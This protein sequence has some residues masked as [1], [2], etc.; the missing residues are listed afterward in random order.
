MTKRDYYDVLNLS[1]NCTQFDIKQSFKRLAL[2]W[3]PDKCA[4]KS[5]A[6]ARFSE[7]NEA[8]NVLADQR[9]KEIYDLYGHKG[10][11]MDQENDHQGVPVTPNFFFQ[12]GFQGS[13]KSAFEV[14][15]DIVKENRDDDYGVFNQ[16]DIF[17]FAN[18]MKAT[19]Q[20]FMEDD[21]LS[22]QHDNMGMSF[23]ETYK[24]TFMNPEFLMPSC[25][26]ESEIADKDYTSRIISFFS[27]GSDEQMYTATSTTVTQNGSFTSSSTQ[28]MYINQN[29]QFRT[30]QIITGKEN[31]S[32]N[33]VNSNKLCERYYTQCTGEDDIMIIN[34]N[35]DSSDDI[36]SQVS[37]K[38]P[39]CN[40]RRPSDE[41]I[42]ELNAH[43]YDSL[44]LKSKKI[45]KDRSS[46]NIRL[47]NKKP[48]KKNRS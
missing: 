11:E 13:E 40:L 35:D 30:E 7:V 34:D 1:S 26:F 39:K 22:T 43:L 9:T 8:Y 27:S 33:Y 37:N 15:Q 2:R 21:E 47:M 29:G 48:S 16:K 38:E 17:G 10:I 36:T 25:D 28:E 18:T 42:E 23:F 6:Q 41:I 45:S 14:L 31:K 24:P 32:S 44:N 5:E 20:S 19:L 3:H 46:L 4:N 12:K